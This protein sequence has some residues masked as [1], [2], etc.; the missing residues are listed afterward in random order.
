M[1][2]TSG[3]RFRPWRYFGSAL[4]L[5]PAI[6]LASLGWYH[7]LSAA[8]A[9]RWDILLITLDTTRADHLGCYGYLPAHTPAIDRLSRDS[10]RYQR[11]YSPAPMTL[12]A[13]C[14]LMTGL[15]PPRHGIHTNREV[16]SSSMETLPEILKKH[17]YATGAVVGAFVLDGRFGLAQGCDTYDD[18]MS[19]GHDLGRFNYIER[20]AQAVTDAA[21]A[22]WRTPQDRPKFLW[23]HYFDPHS[24]YAPPGYDPGSSP[25]MPYDAEIAFVDRQ[26]ERLLSAIVSARRD[27]LVVL[28]ADHGEGL[29]EHGEQTHGLFAYDSTLRVPLIVQFP[30]RRGAGKV[31]TEPVSLVDVMPSMLSWLA[32]PAPEDLDGRSLPLLH[33]ATT[34][35]MPAPRP[36]FF[37]NQYIAKSYG[38]SPLRGIVVGNWKFIDAPRPELYDLANDPGELKN[39]FDANDAHSQKLSEQLARVLVQQSPRQAATADSPEL[40]ELSL[41]KL[42][43]LGYV[44]ESAARAERAEDG[45]HAQAPDPKDMVRVYDQIHA[46]MAQ[47]NQGQV[48]EGVQLLVA[49]IEN[50]SIQPPAARAVRALAALVVE[51]RAA[52]QHGIPCLQRM[53]ERQNWRAVDCSVHESLGVVLIEEGRHAEAVRPLRRLVTLQPD[54]AAGHYVLGRAY[55]EV[56]DNDRAAA[57]FERAIQLADQLDDRP[58]WLDDAKVQM[59]ELTTSLVR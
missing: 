35:T 23:V 52:R 6:L 13:H 51:D 43:S 16:L 21:L 32:L 18:D 50:Q 3:S 25:F 31:V 58:A 45:R 15:D 53:I 26:L 7:L 8:G 2:H 44:A 29:G 33:Q 19:Q 1:E 54:H 42:R 56:G 11:C 24:P 4:V 37:E 48:A 28:T 49:V 38:W 12:P 47:V 34:A 27:T 36:I 14:S 9:P 30:D 39:R 55:R 5:L 40:D 22:W 10:V 59:G 41:R 46:A 20:N 17:G 57:S